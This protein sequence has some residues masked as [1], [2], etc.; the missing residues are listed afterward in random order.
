MEAA[1][2]MSTFDGSHNRKGGA[3]AASNTPADRFSEE[4]PIS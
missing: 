3:E 1:E 2:G 4:F